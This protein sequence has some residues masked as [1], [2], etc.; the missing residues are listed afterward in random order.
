MDFEMDQYFCLEV[1]I[2][3]LSKDVVALEVIIISVISLV[4]Y[5]HVMWLSH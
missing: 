2:S 5:S 1:P 3:F 4:E